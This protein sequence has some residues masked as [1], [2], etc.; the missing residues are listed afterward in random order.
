MYIHND[1]L[2]CRMNFKINISCLLS[3]NI[4]FTVLDEL[5]KNKFIFLY[6]LL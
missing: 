2:N 1:A 6:F 4:I 5:K 3:M